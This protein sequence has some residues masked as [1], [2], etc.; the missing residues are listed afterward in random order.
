MATV[1]T[2]SSLHAQITRRAISPRLAMRIFLNM[3]SDERRAMSDEQVWPS[4]DSLLTAHGSL[5][6]TGK[7]KEARLGAPRNGESYCHFFGL[8]TNNSWP[9][10][11]G[12]PFVASFLMISPATSDS[13]SFSSFMAS[14]MHSTC[15]IS[16][17]SPTLTK[18]GAPG[19][20]AS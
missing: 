17:E 6:K 8:I 1:R 12:C 10:S 15:P 16:T 14:T 5:L 7:R 2:P 4:F 18:G 3:I 11:I 9:Y 13:I 19:E 20:G